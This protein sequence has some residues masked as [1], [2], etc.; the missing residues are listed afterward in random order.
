MHSQGQVGRD[1]FQSGGNVG[2]K[3]HADKKP[4][5]EALHRKKPKQREIVEHEIEA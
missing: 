4:L 2:S 5:T 1:G 3:A